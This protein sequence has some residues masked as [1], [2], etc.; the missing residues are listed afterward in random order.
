MK[1]FSFKRSI[2]KSGLGAQRFLGHSIEF[3]PAS[4]AVEFAIG[5]SLNYAYNNSEFDPAMD[6]II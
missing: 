6:H 4:S 2:G 3:I 1:Y 5:I